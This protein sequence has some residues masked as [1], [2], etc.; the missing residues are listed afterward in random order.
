MKDR[1][2]IAPTTR[3]KEL[4][5]KATSLFQAGKLTE[6]AAEFNKL[7][8]IFPNDVAILNSLGAISLHQG[9]LDSSVKFF[10]KSLK[11]N[12][13]QLDALYNFGL[14]FQRIRRAEDA[15]NCY[16]QIL[17]INPDSPIACFNMGLVFHGQQRLPE[18]IS[19]YDAAIASNPNH[20]DALARPLWILLPFMPDFR[21]MLERD[22]SPWYPTATLFRQTEIGNWQQV[23]SQVRRF[24]KTVLKTV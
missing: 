21:W 4:F 20:V 14:V 5:Q 17:G 6:S 3:H 18:A 8:P 22:D 23:I 7:L 15:I 24:A 16:R 9:Q 12:A 11:I 13:K 19:A 2:S 10:E 1:K